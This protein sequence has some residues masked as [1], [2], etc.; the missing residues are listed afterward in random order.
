MLR[1][2]FPPIWEE[3]HSNERG[4]NNKNII[5]TMHGAKG[6]NEVSR[7]EPS[8]EEVLYIQDTSIFSPSKL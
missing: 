7:H 4:S 5:L 8:V 1:P 3:P 2:I 6:R